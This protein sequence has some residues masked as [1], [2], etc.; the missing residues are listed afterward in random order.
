M[1]GLQCNGG[2][3]FA[4]TGPLC[5]ARCCTMLAQHAPERSQGFLRRSFGAYMADM[6]RCMWCS[7]V[8]CR[9]VPVSVSKTFARRLALTWAGVGTVQHWLS[10]FESFWYSPATR[11]RLSASTGPS[12]RGYREFTFPVRAAWATRRSWLRRLFA[13][14]CGECSGRGRSR[15]QQALPGL[16]R[17]QQNA[18]PPREASRGR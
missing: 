14:S 5:V 2:Q 7:C 16:H 10:R 15:G 8:R 4:T 6:R 9:A 13:I 12:A 3:A 17:S 11:L 1:E 18:K